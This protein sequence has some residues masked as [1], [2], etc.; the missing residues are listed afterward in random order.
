MP[1]SVDSLIYTRGNA[2]VAPTINCGVTSSE[3]L[4]EDYTLFWATRSTG[5]AMSKSDIENG[6]GDALEIGSFTAANINDL[7]GSIDLSTSL[8]AGAIDVFVRDSSG[9]PVESVVASVSSVTYDAAAPVFSSAEVGL[10]D[11]TTLV[12]TFDKA[13]YGSTTAADWDVQVNGSPATESAA[14]I[15]GSTVEITLTVAVAVGA[16]VTVAYNGAGIVGIDAEPV[17]TFTAQAVTNNVV[18]NLVADPGFDNPASWSSAPG[19]GVSGGVL[20]MDG[21]NVGF[22]SIYMN[23]NYFINIPDDTATY[24]L[25]AEITRLVTSGSRIRFTG[26]CYDGPLTSSTQTGTATPQF[27]PASTITVNSTGVLGPY[28]FTVPAGTTHFR[29]QFFAIDAN[30]DMDVDNLVVEMV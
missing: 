29:I 22:A 28:I 25:S 2:G 16:T 10:V 24:E 30:M 1:I 13:L 8:T 5:P 21:T 27:I 3:P 20:N 12:V 4:T 18:S 19:L 23:S 11:S 7:D 14:V 26:V 15:S 17:A 6:T 9:T